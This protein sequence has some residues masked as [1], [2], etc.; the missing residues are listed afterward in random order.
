MRFSII[1]PVYNVEQYISE[2]I[3][4]ILNQTYQDMEI[5]L[6]DDGSTDGSGKI[7]DQYAE[8]H[9][10]K[11]K[12]IHNTNH[13][14]FKARLCG[15]N[16]AEGDAVLFV[17][18]D[19]YIRFDMLELLNLQFEKTA[20]DMILFNASRLED[21]SVAFRDSCFKNDYCFSGETKKTLYEAMI[22]NS[23]MNALCFSAVKT[24]VFLSIPEEYKGFSGRNGEDLLLLLP[25]ITY[26]RR[27]TY[28]NQNLYFYRS[29]PESLVHSYSP[30]RPCSIKMVHTEM[31]KYIDKWGMEEF[32]PIHYAREVRGWVECLKQLLFSTTLP[33]RKLLN[34][35]AE[36]DYFKKAYNNMEHGV[37]SWIDTILGKW[38]YKK[39]YGHIMLAGMIW[40]I[41]R[42]TKRLV[43]GSE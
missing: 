3:D 13:G 40:R 21:F 39:K 12:V 26:A 35:L 7:C 14:P 18:A 33:N 37:L 23:N 38:L 5:I 6:V 15:I 8:L 1:I 22:P 19:D 9:Q 27:I 2:C 41:A 20:C 32:H 4:S 10:V 31:E 24:E 30:E 17:D 34:D 43:R 36:D 16:N 25:L 11:C 28:L 42:G 29:R